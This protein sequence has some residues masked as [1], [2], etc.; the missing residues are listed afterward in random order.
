MTTFEL[1]SCISSQHNFKFL[2]EQKLVS[3]TCEIKCVN[4]FRIYE[5]KC[6]WPKASEDECRLVKK[7]VG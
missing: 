4:Q 5:F 7:S 2:Y 3:S 1:F 6:L